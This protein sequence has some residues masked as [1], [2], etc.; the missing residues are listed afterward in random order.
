MNSFS[1]GCTLEQ[2]EKL[3]GG[4]KTVLPKDPD[5]ITRVCR[6]GPQARWDFERVIQVTPMCI[7]QGL[8]NL[9]PHPDPLLQASF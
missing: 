6:Q 4:S 2:P 5:W 7:Q 8:S 1:L 9:G 3:K